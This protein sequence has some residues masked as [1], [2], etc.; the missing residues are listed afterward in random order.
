[1]TSI[2]IDLGWFRTNSK[3]IIRAV[4]IFHKVVKSLHYLR[5][6]C[7]RWFLYCSSL[8]TIISFLGT[9]E[10]KSSKI[11]SMIIWKND[12]NSKL[13]IILCQW[14]ENLRFAFW[15]AENISIRIRLFGGWKNESVKK[16]K[17]TKI[18]TQKKLCYT[19]LGRFSSWCYQ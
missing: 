7:A 14:K 1:M 6:I 5:I 11:F 3:R 18:L 9:P 8:N 10:K 15:I 13:Y 19:I 16:L 2:K 17:K 12:R 4:K